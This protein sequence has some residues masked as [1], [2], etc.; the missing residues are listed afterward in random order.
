MT[1]QLAERVF[2]IAVLVSLFGL[3]PGLLTLPRESA[4]FPLA[5]IAVMAATT[6]MLL[7]RTWSRGDGAAPFFDNTGRFVV[8]VAAIIAYALAMPR[9]GFF[10]ATALLGLAFPSLFGFR[11]WRMIIPTVGIFIALIWL[12]F[13]RIFQRPLPIE[14]FL[15]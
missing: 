13:V 1:K 3:L 12:I 6:T 14:F 9:L 7:W 2:A 10:T 15:G 11:N 8:A 5:A 4:A